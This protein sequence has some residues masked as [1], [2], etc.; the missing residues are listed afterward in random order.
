MRLSRM[1]TRQVLIYGAVAVC[2]LFFLS[3]LVAVVVR[4]RELAHSA[5]CA[6]NLCQLGLA[7]RNYDS[8][9]GCLPPAYVV[10]AHGKPLYSWRVVLMAYLERQEGWNERQLTKSF[11]FDEPWDSPANSKLHGMRPPNLFCPSHP[12]SAEMGFTSV[13]VVVGP[14]TLF[15]PDGQSRRLADIRD[16]PTSTLMLVESVNPSI[17]WM[18]PRDLDWDQMSFMIN[19]RSCPS[20]SSEH[21]I[22]GYPG[23]HVVTAHDSVTFL[24]D[25]MPPDFLKA[26]LMIDDGVKAILRQGPRLD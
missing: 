22:G 6:G 24:S 18:E 1:K 19:D 20:I 23:P 4:E 21:R 9:Y 14:R 15:P 13:V 26:L 8:T 10:D 17:Y 11:R 16:D 7:L 25:S 2:A 12:V 5:Q 3:Q